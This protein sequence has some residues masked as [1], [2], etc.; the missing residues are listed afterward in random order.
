M[1]LL[2]HAETPGELIVSAETGDD[3]AV[4]R[5]PDGRALIATVDVFTPIVDDA[6]DW[7]R[8]AATNAFS[9]V[10]AMGGMPAF[11]LNIAGWPVDDLPLDLLACVLQGG[12]DVAVNAGAVV[13]GGHTITATE[14]IYG[15]V[16]LGFAEEDHVMRNSTAAPGEHL[17]LTKPIGTG[18]IATAIKRE[19]ANAEQAEAAVRTMTTLNDAAAG[20]MVEAGASAATD[21][22][23]FGLLGHLRKLL[24]ASGVGA[25]VE[26]TLVPTLPGV[27]DLARAGVVSGG[28][29]RNHAWLGV[30]TDWG[31]LTQPEQLVLAD[32]QTSGGLLIA[33]R[34]A[35]AL[36]TA[37][38]ARG[39]SYAEIGEVV[40]GPPGTIA[41]DGRL[42]E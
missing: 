33:T 21:V 36:R 40:A 1:G 4:W 26:A 20:A 9:D 2:G 24:E 10:Y 13:A 18:L 37:L 22:T 35:D 42:R 15:M 38:D 32:A 7:G 25:R 23:G 30:T 19:R 12:Q 14:P 8:I 27:L 41:V 31:A 28:T 17:F 34:H 3:A 16:A 5:L 11:A 6:Y 29:N 39:V